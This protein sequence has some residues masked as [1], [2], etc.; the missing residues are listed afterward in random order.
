MVVVV[1]TSLS[2][3]DTTILTMSTTAFKGLVKNYFNNLNIV[4]RL[5]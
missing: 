5:N 2:I 3:A 4:V 1:L